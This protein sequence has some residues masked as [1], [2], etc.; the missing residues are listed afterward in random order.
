[1]EALKKDE[2]MTDLARR[3]LLEWLGAQ[4]RLLVRMIKILI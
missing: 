4:D 2:A 3:A 1:M